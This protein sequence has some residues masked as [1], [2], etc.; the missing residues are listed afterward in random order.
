MR[1]LVEAAAVVCLSLSVMTGNGLTV[2]G[3]T[4]TVYTSDSVELETPGIWWNE[5]KAEW[6]EVEN[7]Y[8]YE[9]RIYRDG[10]RVGDTV[11]T[12]STKYDVRSR[13]TRA[14]EYTFQVRA[15]AKGSKYKNS[16]WS[17][18]S[19][20]YV[21]DAEFAKRI[22]E[23]NQQAVASVSGGKEPGD[24]SGSQ[25]GQTVTV[26]EGWKLDNTGW[27]WQNADGTYPVNQWRYLGSKWYFFNESGYMRTGW[28]SW[29][30]AWYYCDGSG[31]MLTD[32]YTPDGY[33]VDANGVCK[34]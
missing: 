17:E 18:L 15:L 3:A 16:S 22:E 30:G 21:V 1:R 26:T 32:T 31:A 6:D 13:M 33:Y 7:A 34:M 20:V 28:V 12:K 23:S 4:N 29:N 5:S 25:T 14:G 11:K 10:Y 27:W 2:Y 9:V 8:Q 24:F 19:D